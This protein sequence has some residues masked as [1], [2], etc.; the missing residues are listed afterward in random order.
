LLVRPVILSGGQGSRLWP[1]SLKNRPKQFLTFNGESSF[2]KQTLVRVSKQKIFKSPI[3]ICNEN[4]KFLVQDH[5]DA[6]G[7]SEY[8][9][10]VEP[11][12]KNTGP[13]VIAGI[14]SA[15]E[16]DEKFLILPSDHHIDS[17]D[18]FEDCIVSAFP[19]CR[20]SLVIFGVKPDKP[21]TA[22]GYIKRSDTKSYSG[23]YVEKFIEKPDRKKANLF[24]T[25]NS[26]LWNSGMLLGNKSLIIEQ[27]KKF[28]P[29][30][31]SQISKA[32]ELS[33]KDLDFTKLNSEAYESCINESID[34]ALL[35][36]SQSTVV[37]P[38][39][40]KWNDIGSWASIYDFFLKKDKNKNVLIGK[41][42]AL[43]TKNS[44][45][46]SNNKT[47]ATYGVEDL[48]IVEGPN[49]FLVANI[50][51]SEDVKK[52]VNSLNFEDLEQQIEIYRPWG[53]YEVID[54]GPFH[55]VKRLVVKEDGRLSLQ[56]HKYRSEHW[57]VVEGEGRVIKGNDTVNLKKGESI[58]IPA[59]V[60]HS[61]INL[62]PKR[63]VVIEVQSG[64]Y[65]G[66]D[67]IKR[68]EDIYGRK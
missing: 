62:L 60:K 41:S 53:H 32:V 10:V 33:I 34:Y 18:A 13:A 64:S 21:S 56:S 1:L 17:V 12:S 28:R 44:L 24:F 2:F 67:D 4:Q 45:I 48:M 37:V 55:Q 23:Y 59:G 49:A 43:N 39:K 5:C 31:L 57:V 25:D 46:Y 61:L 63:L 26:Y 11:L 50:N 51:N 30:M 35:E 29:E 19:V 68:F 20:D 14:L 54:S 38:A 15:N 3:I 47:I 52:V 22:Y 40:F 9:I 7:L 65:L 36:N 58:F 16:K 42:L 66:E 8:K 6:I 27:F